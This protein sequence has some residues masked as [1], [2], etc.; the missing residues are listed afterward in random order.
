MVSGMNL[1]QRI[2]GDQTTFGEVAT[3]VLSMALTEGSQSNRIDVVF[4]TYTKR[5]SK[6]AIRGCRDWASVAEYHKH[7]NSEAVEGFPVKNC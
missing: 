6:G 3:T 5:N 1:V 2:K 4:D 7:T